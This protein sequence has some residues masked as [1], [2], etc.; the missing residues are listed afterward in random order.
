MAAELAAN[1]P[2]A[3]DFCVR[4]NLFPPLPLLVARALAK[5]GQVLQLQ[6]GYIQHRRWCICGR[7]QA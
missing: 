5:E 1:G 4:Q 2:L 7:K 3:V 6:G